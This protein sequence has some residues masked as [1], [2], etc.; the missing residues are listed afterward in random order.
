MKKFGMLLSAV[1]MLVFSVFLAFQFNPQIA[2]ARELRECE[3]LGENGRIVDNCGGEGLL[4]GCV[5][6]TGKRQAQVCQIFYN[7]ECSKFK[8]YGGSRGQIGKACGEADLA[9]ACMTNGQGCQFYQAYITCGA[10]SYHNE[11]DGGTCN[12]A[13]NE[14]VRLCRTTGQPLF[15]LWAEGIYGR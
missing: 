9:N 3:V 1:A 15:C 5:S 11:N 13:N 8:Q 4:A 12:R 6:N 10:R 7:N 2:I 14:V